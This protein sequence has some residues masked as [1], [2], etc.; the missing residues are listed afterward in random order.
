MRRV[1]AGSSEVATSKL[2]CYLAFWLVYG[3]PGQWVAAGSNFFKK[4]LNKQA[5]GRIK[6]NNGDLVATL[7]TRPRL[8]PINKPNSEVAGCDLVATPGCYPCIVC[9]R[10]EIA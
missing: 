8:F 9:G 2:G 3:L 7:A 10:N 4:K 6:R 5:K 1:A